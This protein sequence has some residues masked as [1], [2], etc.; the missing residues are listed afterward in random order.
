MTKQAIWILARVI[1][2]QP[3]ARLL[4]FTSQIEVLYNYVD[5]VMIRKTLKK[6]LLKNMVAKIFQKQW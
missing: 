4:L 3:L 2:K 5:I 6:Y 1:R